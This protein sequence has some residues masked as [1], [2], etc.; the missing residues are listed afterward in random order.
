MDTGGEENQHTQ[1]GRHFGV[2][3]DV[4]VRFPPSGEDFGQVIAR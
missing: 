3:G 1:Y 2:H 4:V